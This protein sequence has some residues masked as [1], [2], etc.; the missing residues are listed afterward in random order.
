METRANSRTYLSSIFT[1]AVVLG[2]L[3]LARISSYLLFHSLAE[4]FAITVAACIFMVIWN[5]RRL[6]ENQY[7]LFLGIAYLFIATVDLLHL[8][9]YPGM[10]VF[11]GLSADVP[12]QFWI[13]GRAMQAAAFFIAPS[14]FG[15]KT[16]TRLWIGMWTVIT[17][18]M[19]TLI[20]ATDRFPSCLGPDGLTTFKIGAELVISI[21]LLL[22]LV[23][24]RR[25]SGRF[26]PSVLRA[27]SWSVSVTI[28]SEVV[29]ILY[30]DPYGP[31][32]LLGH[33]LRI[34]ATY[35]LY[36]G[37]IETALVE[38]H[39]VLFREL[40]ASNAALRESDLV[41]RKAMALSDAMNGIDAA[42]N[43]TLDLD[44]ILS[45]AL[46]GSTD[47]LDADSAAIT[48]REGSGWVVRHVYGLS[49]DLVGTRLEEPEARHLFVAAEGRMPFIISDVL[50]DARV[51][52]GL[53]SRYGVTSLL[54]VPL[55]AANEVIGIITFHMRSAS[56]SFDVGGRDFAARL[57]VALAL[58]IENARLYALQ[59]E[60]ADTLQNAMLYF[61]DEL[62]GVALGHAYR[63]ADELALIGG[64]FYAAFELGDGRIGLVLGDVAGKGI[65]AATA[66]SIARTTLHAF[67]VS[68]ARPA[69]VLSAANRVLCRLLPE[70]VFA[71]A[72]YATVD[73][74]T[75]LVDLCSAG[76]PDPFVCTSTGC[77]RHDARRNRPL[78][79]WE[80][81]TY[82]EFSITLNP[83]DSIVLFSDGLPDARR[84][85]EF[86]GEER[87][88]AVLD[89][90]RDADPQFIVDT[91]MADATTFAGDQ[92]TDDI[93]IIA[94]TIR[95]I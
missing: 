88:E 33:F 19:T 30:A 40:S 46:L 45:R 13:L 62:P 26:R 2:L 58:A 76:H 92:H 63:S 57:A 53:M 65:A 18:V 72:T 9:T 38:P 10:G 35:L 84:G 85:T 49:H 37:I 64:D 81:T 17:I 89:R 16:D 23:R 27:L 4:L 56:K 91:L 8:L 36:K 39:S 82:E 47:A 54:T 87:I 74:V 71:T 3:Y 75:G 12:T 25:H 67:S 77:L 61:P 44:Q 83:G 6:I 32:N 95:G 42:V 52:P 60:I 68:E 73:V 29:F 94:A 59:R 80:D 66:S 21:V 7:L 1:G 50:N 24:L 5:S 14:L 48:Y 79:L 15:R 90:L 11:T 22:S 43:S 78:G 34:L 69:D 28:V 31:L 70:G 93:A 86:F 20:L 51:D 55:T 41:T